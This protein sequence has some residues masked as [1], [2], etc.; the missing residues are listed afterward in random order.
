M[1]IMNEIN[2][3]DDEI[4]SIE[5]YD[6]INTI[7]ITVD[8]TH[9]FFAND[10]YTH[11]SGIGAEYVEA[12]QTGGSIKRMQKAHFFMSIAKTPAQQEANFANIRIIKAR[13]AKDGQMF[14]DC[15][16]N[17]DTIKIIIDDPRYRNSQAYKGLKH[18][19]EKGIEIIENKLDI[20]NDKSSDARI[21]VAINEKTEGEIINKANSE[22]IN[23]MLRDNLAP[24]EV[25]KPNTAFSSD[26]E[27]IHISGRDDFNNEEQ[28]VL[29]G[30]VNEAMNE[31]ESGDSNVVI[32]AHT[33][34]DTTTGTHSGP[35]GDPP[36][37]N[38]VIEDILELDGA[39]TDATSDAV[40]EGVSDAVNDEPLLNWS[41]ETTTEIVNE[42]EEIPINLEDIES[43]LIDP[44][45]PQGE[46][47]EFNN[48]LVK[49][50]DY[51]T[52]IT[53]E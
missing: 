11:N 6:E 53:K 40:N 36:K 42:P 17:N 24:E 9:M 3:I 23:D 12:Q 28:N 37:V 22:T 32:G 31:G 30:N 15:V 43:K 26:V 41:G 21:H 45:E 50:R 48:M 2:L 39:V 35:F 13:F 8:D 52:V 18:Y 33:Q 25:I 10:I 49:K 7:D 5:E 34:M 51:Q 46:D 4:V 1:I 27:N 38:I 16:F 29:T 14:E 19:D 47:M 44:D 20:L